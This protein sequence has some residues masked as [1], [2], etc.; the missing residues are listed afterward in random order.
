MPALSGW[1]LKQGEIYQLDTWLPLF[2]TNGV[3]MIIGIIIMWLGN[4][5]LL[6]WARGDG[7]TEK[8]ICL[9]KN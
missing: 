3:G 4:Y 5:T 1:I 6:K 2:Y 8:D 7:D 9:N